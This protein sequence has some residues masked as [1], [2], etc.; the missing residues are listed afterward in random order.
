MY[1]ITTE[2][3][4]L[5]WVSLFKSHR[6]KFLGTFGNVSLNGGHLVIPGQLILSNNI[7]RYDIKPSH[8][9]LLVEPSTGEDLSCFITPCINAYNIAFGKFLDIKRRYFG[10]FLISYLKF[11][12]T[13][14]ETRDKK[15]QLFSDVA[16]QIREFAITGKIVK[17]DVVL[18]M[19]LRL[20]VREMDPRSRCETLFQFSCYKR[21]L[22]L[23]TESKVLQSMLKHREVS[24][25]AFI[26]D[27]AFLLSLRRFG[28]KFGDK[29]KKRFKERV[30]FK[31]CSGASFSKSRKAGG[32]CKELDEV[33]TLWLDFKLDYEEVC[34]LVEWEGKS[35]SGVSLFREDATDFEF[36][37][38]RARRTFLRVTL[39][40]F[41]VEE[42]GIVD[43]SGSKQ[44]FREMWLLEAC[45]DSCISSGDYT[46]EMKYT[47][48]KENG[49]KVRS[50]AKSA[51][52]YTFLLQGVGSSLRDLLKYEISCRGA[53]TGDPMGCWK[54]I[55]R[56][57]LNKDSGYDSLHRRFPNEKWVFRSADLSQATD[58][59]P[60]DVCN[61]LIDGLVKGLRLKNTTLEK[62]MYLSVGEGLI[63]YPDGVTV[64]Q[65]R[66]ISMGLP[67]SWFLL[68]LYNLWLVERSWY[69]ALRIGGFGTTRVT[70]CH[71]QCGDDLVAYWPESVNLEYTRL[72]VA[73]GGCLS[74]G[75]DLVDSESF[76]FVEK[77]G[78]YDKSNHR[79]RF[80][81]IVPLR[82]ISRSPSCSEIPEFIEAGA[83]ISSILRPI[84]F[85]SH[86]RDVVSRVIRRSYSDLLVKLTNYGLNPYV[87][88][89]Y[90]G[91]GFP[92]LS[93]DQACWRSAPRFTRA[94]RVMLSMV[95]GINGVRSHVK[96]TSSWAGIS[97]GKVKNEVDLWKVVDDWI[98]EFGL[99]NLDRKRGVYLGDSM[100][101]A[102]SRMLYLESHKLIHETQFPSIDAVSRS[103]GEET[104]RLNG[105]VPFYK[106]SDKVNNMA[107][108]VSRSV[109]RL[110][111]HFSF[112]GGFIEKSLS[113]YLVMDILPGW[114]K[115]PIG[116]IVSVPASQAGGPMYPGKTSPSDVGKKLAGKVLAASRVNRLTPALENSLAM[117]KGDYSI[118][119]VKVLPLPDRRRV[120]AYLNLPIKFFPECW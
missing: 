28:E 7:R 17:P 59:M 61:S 37:G 79:V 6:K 46:P 56:N 44:F 83:S 67:T 99:V 39:E 26:T 24:S 3:M 22:P 109:F 101:L 29:M 85:G 32:A 117:L 58:L 45:L 47:S 38:S 8:S 113:N 100:Q 106:L 120:V 34:D 96:F 86:K 91:G 82:S 71:A 14:A 57:F 62:L 43:E 92:I 70:R 65:V 94:Y 97:C 77:S 16:A 80:G 42:F 116:S 53:V 35:V 89:L 111:K 15:L 64:T 21:A 74:E 41:E 108:G 25:N 104:C 103:I 49:G 63:H 107:K 60:K 73:T 19:I 50:L 90:G 20:L 9:S 27:K 13:R 118:P 31:P 119:K 76:N 66:G 68:N 81:L 11:L 112:V 4:I 84:P 87:D 1:D 18:N 5:Q 105:L 75:K 72:L 30:F 52:A 78:Y 95:R 69:K 10:V 110:T 33:L 114:G 2:T 98:N 102:F 40:P 54:S 51:A 36:T 12:A 23:P 55:I 48:V 93:T 115:A 88:R